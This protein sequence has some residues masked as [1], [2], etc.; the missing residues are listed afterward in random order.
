M[1]SIALEHFRKRWHNEYLISLREKH[2]NQCAENSSNYLKVEQ[3][4]MVKHDNLH[5]IQWPLWVITAVYPD[6]RGV[7]RTAEVEECG[8]RSIRSVTFLVPLEL[9]CHQ[10][11]DVI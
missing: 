11:D 9:D 5:R 8:R 6:E 2:Y 10:E 4:V 7:I 3:L 1:L